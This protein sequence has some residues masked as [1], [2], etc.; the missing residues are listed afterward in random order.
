MSTQYNLRPDEPDPRDH[1][2]ASSFSNTQLP[3]SVDLRKQKGVFPPIFN[4]GNLNSC[5]AN[6]V[7]A[8]LYFDMIH[9]KWSETFTPSRLFIYHNELAS[10]GKLNDKDYAEHGAT[11]KMRD[12]LKTVD[13][14]GFCSETLWPYDESKYNINPSA[15]ALAEAKKYHS[16][17]Y[18][19]IHHQDLNQI[20]ACLA[21]GLPFIFGIVIY[22]S[23]ESDQVKQ[24]GKVP[25][26]Q[27]GDEQLG[28]H[29]IVGVGYDDDQQVFIFRNS[30]GEDWGDQGYG[31][32][33]YSFMRRYAFDFWVIQK[34]ISK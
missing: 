9:Q 30:Y 31:Y 4:Q 8:I 13:S 17:E 22:K 6:A 3:A 28:A 14:D 16:Y 7:S 29:A 32:L 21:S 34:I 33:P 24:S 5:T 20:K 23:F 1:G 25:L 11:V 15:A 19:R 18:Q 10:E 12:C 2:Y 26:P 27:P